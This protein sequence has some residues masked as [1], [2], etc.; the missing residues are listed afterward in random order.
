[1]GSSMKP[2]PSNRW[3]CKDMV[4]VVTGGNTGIGFALVRQLAMLGL[5]VVLTCRD[6][7]KGNKAVESLRLQ[8]LHV[9]FFRL[10]VLDHSS[11]KDFV[12][13]L[14]ET[15]GGLDI[16]VN[17]AA[18]SFKEI[19][20]NSVV[21]AETV[22]NTNFYGPKL[23]TEALLPFFR[24]SKHMSRILNISSRLGSLNKVS[25][26]TVR[27]I[28]EDE[29]NL[30]EERIDNIVQKFLEDVRNGVWNKNGWPEVWTD[31]AVS[32]L[33]LNAYSKL[34]AKRYDGHG[35]SVNCYCPG[36][37]QTS[38]THGKGKHTPGYVADIGAKLVLLPPDQL[39]SGKFYV[40]SNKFLDSKL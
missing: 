34:L 3:W 6:V 14:R 24:R 30:S 33:A 18:V 38:M 20:E 28:L 12:S 29:E 11:I 36:F 37:T 31:Y 9:S 8:G 27:K 1:M 25:N 39:P 5:S 26:P 16:L 35:L 19:G 10:D 15:L 22:I 21:H 40:T 32:K 4:A 13:W 2:L 23:L 7:S 17:N